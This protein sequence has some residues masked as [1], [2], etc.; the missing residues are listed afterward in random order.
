[1][2]PEFHLLAFFLDDKEIVMDHIHVDANT[3]CL[4]NQVD[5]KLG[6][7]RAEV[8]EKISLAI[9][10]AENSL[11]ALSAVDKSVTFLGKKQNSLDLDK[12]RN[13]LGISI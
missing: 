1:M 11:C 6:K 10:S 12:V 2:S 7:Q 5:L 9:Q 4:G 3:K 13:C 8:G